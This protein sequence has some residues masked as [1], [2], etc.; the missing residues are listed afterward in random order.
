MNV[1]FQKSQKSPC[2]CVDTW[3]TIYMLKYI[4]RSEI[5]ELRQFAIRYLNEVPSHA[6]LEGDTVE[7]SLEDRRFISIYQA[8]IMLLNRKKALVAGFFDADK[9]VKFLEQNSETC[10]EE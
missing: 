8:S 10:W 9:P 6:C 4:T 7:I 1:A 5:I 3:Y 2:R